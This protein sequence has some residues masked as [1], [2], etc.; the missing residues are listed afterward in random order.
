VTA[1][2]VEFEP[3]GHDA[4]T[5][6]FRVRVAPPGGGF[7]LKVRPAS[8]RLDVAGRVAAHLREAGLREVVAPV[9]ALDGA[10]A[11]AAGD[12]SV[13]LFPFIEGRRG[14]DGGL[15]DGQWERLGRF[16]RALHA[17]TL[18]DELTGLIP[19]ETFRPREVEAFSRVDE[20]A[21]NATHHT[22]EARELAAG[23]RANRTLIASLVD[24]TADLAR[25]VAGRDL[26]LVL[27][28]ADS[29][30]GN[31]LV[32]DAGDIWLIDW[33][34]V[35]MAPKERD[36]MFSVGG[37]SR[38]LVSEPATD[39]FLA[40]YGDTAIDPVAMSYYRFAWATQDVVGYAEQVL[41]ESSR[42]DED[43]A[44]AARIFPLLFKPGEIVDIA[45]STEA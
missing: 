43:R 17:T 16:I 45:L 28:H 6:A 40:G 11:I 37:I 1:T 10:V 44:E 41:V 22:D 36:L 31:I 14:L 23:W 35:V 9:R 33:D 18:P 12:V 32:D 3:S 7:L 13:A 39:H 4:S 29:H 34:E 5:R 26:P 38:E 2:A 42:S 20:A 30:T 25:E 21:M 19:R 27:C 15:D 24:R 8:P